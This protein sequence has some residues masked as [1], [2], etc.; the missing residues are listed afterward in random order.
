MNNQQDK[1]LHPWRNLWWR[2]HW[3]WRAQ[4]WSTPCTSP[5][6]ESC[7]LWACDQSSFSIEATPAWHKDGNKRPEDNSMARARGTNREV[8]GG[9]IF[10]WF[11]YFVVVDDFKID[12]HTGIRYHRDPGVSRSRNQNLAVALTSFRHRLFELALQYTACHRGTMVANVFHES[13]WQN[14]KKLKCKKL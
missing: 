9:K 4:K 7:K 3:L 14:G 11:S 1:N 5:Q 13:H 2:Q 6:A 8:S 12:R 10:S